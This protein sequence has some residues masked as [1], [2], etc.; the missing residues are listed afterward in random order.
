MNELKRPANRDFGI[1]VPQWDTDNSPPTD[2]LVR[3]NP[4]VTNKDGT[5]LLCKIS[6]QLTSEDNTVENS[7]RQSV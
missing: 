3:A 7:A 1:S 2:D 6:K 5:I 4:R